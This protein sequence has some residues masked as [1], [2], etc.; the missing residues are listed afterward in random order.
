M[1]ILPQEAVSYKQQIKDN[2]LLT[3]LR[4][5]KLVEKSGFSQIL[6][7]KKFHCHRN[8]V[9]NI[10]R[11]FK[12]KYDQKTQEKLL[13]HSYEK[14]KLL[15]ILAPL[16]NKSPCPL[17]HPA[18]ATE[19]QEAA[20]AEWLFKQEGLRVGP[21][22]LKTLIDRRFY[23]SRDPFLQSLV[24]LTARQIRGVYKRYSLS[25][26]KREAIPEPRCIYMIIKH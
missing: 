16:K 24:S 20:I 8:T 13:S 17:R 9:G 25:P 12:N 22:R 3:K 6:V 15:K 21:Y 26:K 11:E 7:A 18:Q 5:I 4:I 2:E 1:N 23:D 14:N 10:V 19:C